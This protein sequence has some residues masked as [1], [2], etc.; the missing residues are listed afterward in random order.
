MTIE[1][2]NNL[3]AAED[4]G[5]PAATRPVVSFQGS[6]GLQVA[7]WKNKSESGIDNYSVRIER[8]YKVGDTFRS[9][10]YLRDSDLLRA[11]KLLGQADA[12]IE[13]DKQK[14]RASGAARG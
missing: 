6:G 9:S 1:E 2:Q 4:I 5:N 7:V 13:Q 12:W 11:E 8:S 10:G 14:L 3:P